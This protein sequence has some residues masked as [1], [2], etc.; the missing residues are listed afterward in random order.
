MVLLCY[1]PLVKY[2][3]NLCIIDSIPFFVY[4][5]KL[6]IEGTLSG[7]FFVKTPGYSCYFVS[8]L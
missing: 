3:K 6:E 2:V 7:I 4:L 8:L 1:Q 5:R